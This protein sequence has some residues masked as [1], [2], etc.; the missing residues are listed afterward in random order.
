[1]E[2]NIEIYVF[3][4][5]IAQLLLNNVGEANNM[6]TNTNDQSSDIKDTHKTVYKC[7]LMEESLEIKCPT[8]TPTSSSETS[9]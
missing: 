1:M 7:Y 3:I 8:E 6:S 4:M 2:K 5:L 9:A